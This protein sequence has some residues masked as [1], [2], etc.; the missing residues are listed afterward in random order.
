MQ[1]KFRDMIKQGYLLENFKSQ[2]IQEDAIILS[3]QI[4]EL[5]GKEIKLL[6]TS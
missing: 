4:S 1:N 2:I 3:L 5:T 6:Y